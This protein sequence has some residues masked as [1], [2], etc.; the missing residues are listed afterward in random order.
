[1]NFQEYEKGIRSLNFQEMCNIHQMILNA[2]NHD[3]DAKE[4]YNELMETS[5]EYANIRAKWLLMNNQEKMNQDSLRTACHNSVIVHLNMLA[6]WLKKNNKDT[7]WRDI[8]G[9]E[10]DDLYNR[11]RMG[12]FA[13][14]LAFINSLLS[15]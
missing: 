3:N 7:Q 11:K 15:R 10:E 1:M 6:R 2:I 4:L 9:Y 13:C 12:D 8:L 5:I 14:Y